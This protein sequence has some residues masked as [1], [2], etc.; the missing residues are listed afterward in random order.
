[1]HDFEDVIETIMPNKLDYLEGLKEE[2]LGNPKHD[3]AVVEEHIARVA[4]KLKAE[5]AKDGGATVNQT[6]SASD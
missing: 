4:K 6:S 2:F 1:M 3:Q 5:V